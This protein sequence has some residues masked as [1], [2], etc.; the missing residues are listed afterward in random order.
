MTYETDFDAAFT[1]LL[2]KAQG[3]YTYTNPTPTPAGGGT[4]SAVATSYSV[5][6]MFSGGGRALIAAQVDPILVEVPDDGEIVWVHLYAGDINAAPVA[7]TATV[8]LQITRWETFG[9]SSPVYG[10]GNPPSL[11][12]DSVGSPSLAGWFPHFQAGDTLIARLSL[13]SGTATWIAMIIKVRRDITTQ[14]QLAV[15]DGSGNLVLDTGG[16]TVVSPN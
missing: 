14:N 5:C 11:Q 3:T 7:V 6:F 12:A 16:N 1:L 13:L 15:L 4:P 10:T 2:G 8:D 9:G